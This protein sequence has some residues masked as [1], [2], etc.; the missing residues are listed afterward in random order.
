MRRGEESLPTIQRVEAEIEKINTSGILPP[1][2][3]LEKI[4]DRSEL[5]ERHDPHR[6]AQHALRHRC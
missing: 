6:A 5:I 2:V 1:G 4:Y 3:R